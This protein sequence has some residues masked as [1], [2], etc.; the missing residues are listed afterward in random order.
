MPTVTPTLTPAES[1]IEGRVWED[2][3]RDGQQDPDE[4]GI[5]EL[6][7]TLKPWSVGWLRLDEGR[8]TTT[9]AAGRYWFEDVV[10]GSYVIQAEDPARYWPTTSVTVQ[11]VAALHQIMEVSFGFYRA[12]VARYL[13]V[14]LK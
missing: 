4:P 12:P 9:D 10:P 1:T 13:P 8:T 6:A 11:L 2:Q 7:I 14:M 3:D 5:A